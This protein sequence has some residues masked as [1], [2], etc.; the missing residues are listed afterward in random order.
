MASTTPRRL[1][2]HLAKAVLYLPYI[3]LPSFFLSGACLQ[4]R[5]GSYA[6]NAQN[7]TFKTHLGSLTLPRKL[8]MSKFESILGD[9]VSEKKVPLHEYLYSR[10]LKL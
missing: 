2:S 8:R 7:L 4:A 3:L 10:V 6:F 1:N 5:T 9:L